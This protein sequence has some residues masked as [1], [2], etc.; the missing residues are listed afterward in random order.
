MQI[1]IFQDM[2]CPWCRI[3]K[4]NLSDA[5]AQ[6]TGEPIHIQYRAY[7]LFPDLPKEGK[8]FLEVM[9]SKG[10]PEMVQQMLSQVTGAGEAAN[11]PF[12]FDKVEKMPNTLASHQFIKSVPA[13]DTA[14]VVDAIYK[15]YFEDGKDIGDLQV[16]LGLAEEL[17]LDRE[18]IRDAIE[19]ERNTDEITADIDF[20]RDNQISGVPFFIIDGKL[21]LSGAHAP[22]NFLKAFHHVRNMEKE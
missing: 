16:L 2:V 9:A 4:K 6:W 17:G 1:E 5:I 19:N 11:L 3:G 7:Q 14:R 12:R 15:A 20:A 22:E 13:A 10:S 8:P 21:A 18:Q